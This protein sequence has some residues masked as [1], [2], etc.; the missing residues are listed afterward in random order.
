MRSIQP[1]TTRVLIIAVCAAATALAYADGQRPVAGPATAAAEQAP[2]SERIDRALEVQGKIGDAHLIMRLEAALGDD[3]GGLWYDSSGTQLHVGVTSQASRRSAEAVA[4][5]AG[6]S[7][8]VVETPVRSTWSELLAAQERWG[9]RL[10]DL[11]ARAEVKTSIAT[12]RNALEVVLGSEVPAAR[13]TALERAASEDSIAVSIATASTPRILFGPAKECVKFVPKTGAN[14]EPQ[15]KAG[16]RIEDE[17][18]INKGCTAGP[19][20]VNVKRT[21]KIPATETFILTA[22]HCVHIG[23]GVTKKWYAFN[24]A[25]A[26][27]EIGKPVNFIAGET[28]IGVVKVEPGNWAKAKDRIPVV[29]YVALWSTIEES[30]PI[31]VTGQENPAM[32]QIVCF[33]GQ[34]SGHLC[35]GKITSTTLQVTS[36]ITTGVKITIKNLNEVAL[37]AGKAGKGDSGAPVVTESDK[38]K[39]LGVLSSVGYEPGTEEGKLYGFQSLKT[40]F[41][42]LKSEKNLELELLTKTNKKRHGEMKAGKYPATIH[43]TTTAG[44]VFTA[45]TSSVEC[46]SDTFH[47]VLTEASSTLTVTPEYKECFASFGASATVTTEGCTYVFHVAAK[48]STDNYRAYTDVSCPAGKSIKIAVPSVGC[49]LEIKPQGE[50]ETVDLVDDTAASPKKDVTVQATVEGIVYT[51]T[52]DGFLCPLGGLGEKSDGKYTGNAATTATGQNPSE[53]AEKIDIEIADA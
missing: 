30:D 40:S 2:A 45:G 46:N 11:F 3:F 37:A 44:E 21:E 19:A 26:K 28:D 41:E 9:Q 50:R 16:V 43:G 53:A 42:K 52:E 32:N 34:R 14:C 7:D 36:E 13:R 38:G 29:P 6:L 31:E 15:I 1:A 12:D 33:S 20:V 22:G 5:R 23:G 48:V 25:G 39:V 18:N 24:K 4:W 35:G 10:A 49:K 17:G 47:A 51:V 8:L 27:S